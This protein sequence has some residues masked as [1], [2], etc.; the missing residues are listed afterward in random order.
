MIVGV[1]EC[2]RHIFNNYY[3]YWKSTN[4]YVN[5]WHSNISWETSAIQFSKDTG[6]NLNVTNIS[7]QA[8]KVFF[9]WFLVG[10]FLFPSFSVSL[11]NEC[12]LLVLVHH[13]V[14]NCSSSDSSECRSYSW[15]NAQLQ[16]LPIHT[17]IIVT[18]VFIIIMTQF[19]I[20][21]WSIKYLD[22]K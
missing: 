16:S 4:N 5:R 18:A 10:C 21:L 13:L 22:V 1:P 12:H 17:M 3:G 19:Q 7:S 14:D 20:C 8:I 11:K 2:K 6:A 9:V 15:H